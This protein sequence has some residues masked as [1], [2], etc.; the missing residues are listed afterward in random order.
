MPLDFGKLGGENTTAEFPLPAVGMSLEF[1]LQTGPKPIDREVRVVVGLEP[2]I[3]C[4]VY[5]PRVRVNGTVCAPIE[6]T[7]C[8]GRFEF[9]VP[10]AAKAD[11]EHVVEVQGSMVE[12]K[13]LKVTR[14]ELAI[15]PPV[16]VN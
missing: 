16:R 10:E 11:E 12:G 8:E 4:S 9:S 5:R 6:E 2:D 15:G 7:S 13:F 3:D 1:R 14:L